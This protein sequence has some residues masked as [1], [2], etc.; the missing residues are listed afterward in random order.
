M[1][2]SWA[3]FNI[4]HLVIMSSSDWFTGEVCSHSFSRLLAAETSGNNQVYMCF[5]DQ[6]YSI[7]EVR[8]LYVSGPVR[9]HFQ[10]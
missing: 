4:F 1:R 2:Q 6:R 10:I 8:F 9:C 3:E 5:S 7:E